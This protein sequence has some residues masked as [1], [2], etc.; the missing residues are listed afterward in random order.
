MD[1]SIEGKAS[2]LFFNIIKLLPKQALGNKVMLSRVNMFWHAC[3]IF[4]ACI[5]RLY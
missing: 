1:C 5:W 4:Q 3:S 2:A